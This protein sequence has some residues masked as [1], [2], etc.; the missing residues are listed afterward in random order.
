MG[1]LGDA[2]DSHVALHH[3]LP[4][5]VRDVAR[6]QLVDKLNAAVL[7]QLLRPR[8]DSGMPCAWS[9]A[10][11]VILTAPMIRLPAIN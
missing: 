3:H 7:A 8:I 6:A 9:P 11:A 5:P 1:S 4:Q 2:E 10:S